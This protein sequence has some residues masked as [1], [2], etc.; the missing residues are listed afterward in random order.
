MTT[1]RLRQQVE[2]VTYFNSSSYSY[3][4]PVVSMPRRQPVSAARAESTKKGHIFD[5]SKDPCIPASLPSKRDGFL[6]STERPESSKR[7]VSPP[8][9]DRSE[10]S[11][12]ERMHALKALESF[13]YLEVKA[14]LTRI[15]SIDSKAL[16]DQ[17]DKP[18]RPNW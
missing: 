10:S 7:D 18:K 17:I 3:S 5:L 4:A 12:V 1:N 15:A 11:H 9:T 16:L 6:S 2:R 8:S 13:D 14:A